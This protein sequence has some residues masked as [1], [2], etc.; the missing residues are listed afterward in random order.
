[1]INSPLLYSIQVFIGQECPRAHIPI[2]KIAFCAFGNAVAGWIDPKFCF[3]FHF[4]NEDK[5]L[6]KH[7]DKY[8]SRKKGWNIKDTLS[9]IHKIV[10]TLFLLQY[11]LL[12]SLK[13]NF[14]GEVIHQNIKAGHYLT[15]TTFYLKARHST[16]K[17]IFIKKFS[18]FSWASLIREIFC[19]GAPTCGPC[20][21]C[22]LPFLSRSPAQNWGRCCKKKLYIL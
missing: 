20:C 18:F 7:D 10:S 2:L 22:L 9:F 16:S 8:I 21:W 14:Q 4:R 5:N 12:P 11:S 17:V 3:T 1:M 6:H 19:P 15:Q 13:C